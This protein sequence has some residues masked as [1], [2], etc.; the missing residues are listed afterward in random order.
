M[1][2]NPLKLIGDIHPQ[3]SKQFCDI[4]H[5]PQL[6]RALYVNSCVPRPLGPFRW[7]STEFLEHTLVQSE[8]LSRKWASEPLKFAARALPGL[9]PAHWDLLFGRWLIWT[10]DTT[11]LC[12]HDL[13]TGDEQVLWQVEES[14]SFVAYPTTSA[15]GRMVNIILYRMGGAGILPTVTFVNIFI[16]SLVFL[17]PMT[18]STGTC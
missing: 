3:V 17:L 13:E 8:Q 9:Y 15:D 18:E 14:S 2:P 11:D 7:Q 16:Q 6:W 1:S 4:A 12:S 5:D 10:D